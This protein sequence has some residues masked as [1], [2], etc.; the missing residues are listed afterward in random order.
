MSALCYRLMVLF[1]DY[2]CTHSSCSVVS[3]PISNYGSLVA[4]GDDFV[5]YYN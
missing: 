2:C 5:K 4:N 3:E 1:C